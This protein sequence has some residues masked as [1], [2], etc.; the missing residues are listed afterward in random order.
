MCHFSPV[1]GKVMPWASDQ[2]SLRSGVA[3]AQPIAG[4]IGGKA[5]DAGVKG[6]A[7]PLG[8]GV[9]GGYAIHL[10]LNPNFSL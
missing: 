6:G 7:A 5:P 4:G 1:L 3:K 9:E 8:E 2:L 10:L